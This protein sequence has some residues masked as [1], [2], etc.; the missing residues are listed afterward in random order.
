MSAVIVDCEGKGFDTLRFSRG[1][2]EKKVVK[3]HFR[4]KQ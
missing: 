1:E 4:L 2:R 3:T